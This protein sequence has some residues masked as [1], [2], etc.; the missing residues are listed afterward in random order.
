ML[1]TRLRQRL[2]TDIKVFALSATVPDFGAVAR[3]WGRPGPPLKVIRQAG[4]RPGRLVVDRGGLSETRTWLASDRAPAKAIL[5]ANSGRRCNEL[6]SAFRE[7]ATTQSCCTTRI[8][9][10]VNVRTRAPARRS[11]RAVCVATSTLELGIDVGDIDAVGLA[12]APWSSLSLVQRVGR[13][14]R[15]SGSA[16]AR[17][18]VDT[19][20]A[21]IRILAAWSAD[22]SI[23]AGDGVVPRFA[24]VAVQQVVE[25]ILASGKRRI[26]AERLRDAFADTDVLDATAASD[27]IEHSRTRACLYFTASRMPTSSPLQPTCLMATI[28]GETSR[29]IEHRGFSLQKARRCPPSSCRATVIRRCDLVWRTDVACFK[30]FQTNREPR[31]DFPGCQSNS[32]PIL[33]PPP[34]VPASMAATMRSI[35]TSVDLPGEVDLDPWLSGRLE[36]LRGRLVRF[37]HQMVYR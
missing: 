13:G 2:A 20:R 21:L 18:F 1:L 8:L 24:S 29:L 22:P 16:E 6:I 3:E 26:H 11:Q 37:S 27:L 12:D 4:Q 34:L 23:A 33:G 36:E 28:V 15:R 5:F 30:H 9:K 14:G 25:L 7:R 31:T 35:I 19:D 17:A 32:R 10:R